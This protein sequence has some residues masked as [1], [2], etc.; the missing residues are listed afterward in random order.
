MNCLDYY[1]RQKDLWEDAEIR[2]LR[3]EYETKEMTISEI[4]DIH[5]RTP[6]VISYKLKSMGIITHNTFARGYSNY[7]NSNL[8]K[9]I[10][11]KS[12]NNKDQ[13]EKKTTSKND[14]IE[15]EED[16]NLAGHP[17]DQQEDQQLIK[18]Y[19]VD[20]LNLSEI[21]KIHQ[22]TPRGI[23]SRLRRLNVFDQIQSKPNNTISS[24]SE[25]SELKNEIISLKKDVKEILRLIH[26][27]YEF[28]TQ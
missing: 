2:Q 27:L 26:Q 17:W 5:R 10:V 20:K 24:N 1:I 25:I 19:T 22:R 13:N 21:S 16:C 7:K 9:E 4:A 12:T 6:G 3:S 14:P 15:N 28:E 18:E 23:K 8:Y 11:E